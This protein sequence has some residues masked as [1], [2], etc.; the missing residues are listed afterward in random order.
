[1]NWWESIRRK[2]GDLW[3]GV[4]QQV[5]ALVIFAVVVWLV[6]RLP[7]LDRF[8][9]W[10]LFVGVIAFCL[11]A[12]VSRVL[13]QLIDSGESAT[14]ELP[15]Y[16]DSTLS[17]WIEC[18][19]LQVVRENLHPDLGGTDN[20]SFEQTHNHLPWYPLYTASIKVRLIGSGVT[21]SL[22]IEMKAKNILGHSNIQTSQGGTFFPPFFR[23][24]EGSVEE[25]RDSIRDLGPN[26]EV[27][28]NVLL[29]Q[30]SVAG[31]KPRFL[32][33][34]SR[35]GCEVASGGWPPAL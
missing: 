10:V 21:R 3:S 34:V 22:D 28:Y 16:Q 15:N 23:P 32:W 19:P 11:G 17:I 1:M 9:S 29:A 13:F 20:I 4:V 2:C 7:V 30:H 25:V 33:F 6:G 27:K 24:V 26:M 14:V 31:S 12:I 5:L 35:D 8:W 18:I